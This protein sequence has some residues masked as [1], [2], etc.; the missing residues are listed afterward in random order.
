MFSNN[1]MRLS[2]LTAQSI[3]FF[4]CLTPLSKNCAAKHTQFWKC[5]HCDVTKR[6][7]CFCRFPN[8]WKH[9]QSISLSRMPEP[10]GYCFLLVAPNIGL[11]VVFL[12]P[13]EVAHLRVNNG[14]WTME[15]TNYTLN[16]AF[17]VI[18]PRIFVFNMDSLGAPRGDGCIEPS[19]GPVHLNVTRSVRGIKETQT[20][21]SLTCAYTIPQSFTSARPPP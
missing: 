18:L 17:N 8:R 14:Q 6:L 1:Y 2:A 13:S 20:C 16:F 15:R 5:V 3:F 12:F 4:G 9:Q 11:S 10:S 7:P 19:L 21:S